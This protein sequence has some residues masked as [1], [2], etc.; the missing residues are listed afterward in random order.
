M[1]RKRFSVIIPAYNVQNYVEKAINS[2][3]EQD[4]KDYELIVVD[5]A[6]TDNT[7]DIVKKYENKYDNVKLISHKDNKA[8]R[9]C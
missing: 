6:S 5:D 9:W 1:E 8:S 3:L 4:F 2:V 7:A